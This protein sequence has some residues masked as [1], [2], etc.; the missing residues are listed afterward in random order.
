MRPFS[1]APWALPVAFSLLG[2]GSTAKTSAPSDVPPDAG[3]ETSMSGPDAGGVNDATPDVTPAEGAAEAAMPTGPGVL[4]FAGY[5]EAPL[6]D[7]WNWD[8]TQWTQVA[9]ST[10]P[11][12][13]SDQSMV[14]DGAGGVLLFGGMGLGPYLGDTWDWTGVGGWKQLQV[15]G[16]SAREGAA[17]AVLNGKIIL[18]GG[19]SASNGFLSDTWEWDGSKWTQLTITGATPGG[20]YG[21]SM[22]TLGNQVV[23]FGNVGGPT[24]TWLFDGT[25]WTKSPATGPTGESGGLSDSRGVQTMATLGNQVILF[26]GEQDANHILGDTWAFDGTAWK[27]LTPAHAPAARYHAGTTAFGGKLVLFGGTGAIPSGV[28]FM[29]DTWTFDGTDWTQASSTG[30]SGRYGYVLAAH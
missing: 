13:R 1:C 23:L 12:L 20:R 27:Q 17:T 10:G 30:P 28:P 7:T 22:A 15:T 5:G 26:G 6:D 4:L 16:P 3:S 29:G 24:D 11:S 2:C 14:G 25:A 8:G 21:H 19:S 18:Y 9:D